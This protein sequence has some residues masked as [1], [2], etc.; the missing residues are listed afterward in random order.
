MSKITHGFHRP[1][2]PRFGE[3]VRGAKVFRHVEPRQARAN[4]GFERDSSEDLVSKQKNEME[5]RIQS[6]K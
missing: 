4:A 5:E 1:S 3:N 2:T 6:G